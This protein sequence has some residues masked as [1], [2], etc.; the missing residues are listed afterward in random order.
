VE[1][2]VEAIISKENY[3]KAVIVSGDSDFFYLIKYLHE[4]DKLYKV[5]VPNIV[6]YAK[7]FHSIDTSTKRYVTFVSDL[8]D[9][10]QYKQKSTHKDETS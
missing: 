8:K 2:S 9:R 10:L 3:S 5:L 1:L 7:I 4:T 6:S